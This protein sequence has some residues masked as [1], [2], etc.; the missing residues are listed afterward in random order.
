MEK[1]AFLS[2]SE[3]GIYKFWQIANNS[4]WFNEL[5][6]DLR[7][8]LEHVKHRIDYRC[9]TACYSYRGTTNAR[10]PDVDFSHLPESEG[11]VLAGICCVTIFMTIPY[12]IYEMAKNV[13]FVGE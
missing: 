1:S 9:Y 2:V 6:I 10:R 4:F 11:R 7:F 12:Q 5:R 3:K 13:I 8:T